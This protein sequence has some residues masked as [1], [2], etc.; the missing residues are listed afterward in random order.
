MRYPAV[1]GRFYPAEKDALLQSIGECFE[2][3]IG[4][5]RIGECSNERTVKGVLCPH[6]GYA[7][8]GMNAAHSYK[9]IAEDGLPDAYVIIGP[10]HYGIPFDAALCTESYLTPLG[11][12]KIHLK[13]ADKLA[14]YV[15]DV[16]RA[17]MLEHSVEVQVPFIQY[18]DEDPLIVPIIMSDQSI[19]AAKRLG[20]AIKEACEGYD[21]VVIASS[22][23]SHYIPKPLAEKKDM[24]LLDR[25]CALD[26]EGMYRAIDDNDISACG[27]GPIASLVYSTGPSEVQ[28]L[29]HSDSWDALG[30]QK[31]SV[32]GYA[33]AVFRG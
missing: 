23:M 18:I 12:C 11:E 17:H 1:A 3:P 26:M 33:S 5:G 16:S 7:C 10:D 20:A 6:A 24:M 21:V 14:R 28:L 19:D 9:R 29:K 31:D 4:P 25:M 30:Y 27:Y 13:I 15:P 8:S 22:D 2:H 32:V